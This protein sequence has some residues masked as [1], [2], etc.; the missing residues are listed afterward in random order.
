MLLYRLEC[1]L[2]FWLL[3]SSTDLHFATFF[4][5]SKLVKADYYV[6]MGAMTCVSDITSPA[7][8]FEM[9]YFGIIFRFYNKYPGA[10]VLEEGFPSSTMSTGQG[11]NTLTLVIF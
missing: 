5:T 10:I 11:V 1:C 6:S 8:N 9:I 7:W 2:H 4:P 3:L